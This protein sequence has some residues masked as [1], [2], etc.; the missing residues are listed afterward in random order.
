MQ[1]LNGLNLFIVVNQVAPTAGSATLL[2]GALSGNVSGTMSS[3]SILWPNPNAVQIGA[4]R[5]AV[6]NNPLGI[7]PPSTNGGLTSIQA[8]ITNT[9][10]PEPSAF[11]LLAMGL[12]G[13][14]VLP[15]RRKG[16]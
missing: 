9:V 1:S 3:A 4:I 11:V 8:S 2:A 12:L 16:A 14:V 15:R 6:L 5:Y 13:L 10:I 7:V